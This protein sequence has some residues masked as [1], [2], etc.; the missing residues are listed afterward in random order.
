MFDFGIENLLPLPAAD[1]FA[2]TVTYRIEF[3]CGCEAVA[4][5][6]WHYSG[7]WIYG[8]YICTLTCHSGC[9]YSNRVEGIS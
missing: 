7:G 6:I 3:Q 5:Y 4:D 8:I 2:E 9:D 1:P